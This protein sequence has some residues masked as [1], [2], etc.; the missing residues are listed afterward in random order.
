MSMERFQNNIEKQKEN[1]LSLLR[2]NVAN[3]KLTQ[4]LVASCLFMSSFQ[5]AQAVNDST[6]PKDKEKIENQINIENENVEAL[7]GEEVS[8]NPK[9][10]DYDLSKICL[11][12]YE[13]IDK[14]KRAAKDSAIAVD[15]AKEQIKKKRIRVIDQEIFSLKGEISKFKQGQSTEDSLRIAREKIADLISKKESLKN[16]GEIVDYSQEEENAIFEAPFLLQDIQ[17]AREDI[18]RILNDPG[19]VDRLMKEFGIDKEE[20]IKHKEVRISNIENAEIEFKFSDDIA[21]NSPGAAGYFIMNSNKIYIPINEIENGVVAHELGHLLTNGDKGIS[22]TQKKILSKKTFMA[23]DTKDSINGMSLNDYHKIT[24]ERYTRLLSLKNELFF[25]KIMDI[26]D[27]FTKDIYKKMIKQFKK[28]PY[29]FGW[30][31]KELIEHTEY[32]DDEEKGYENFRKMFEEIAMNQ[33]GNDNTY[34][35]RDWNYDQP[36]NNA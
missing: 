16:G 9:P 1:V 7:G 24:T 14:Q 12:D 25:N 29:S 26:G 36:Q 27:H 32:W 6:L 13:N 20:A 8:K 35:H 2:D 5:S 33:N 28:R 23:V 18:L 10:E 30:D 11:I 34:R 15:F 31:A 17:Q 22:N 19:Y 21:K 3:K 4:A